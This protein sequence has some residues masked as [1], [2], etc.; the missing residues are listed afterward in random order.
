M[1]DHVYIKPVEV[2]MELFLPH[3]SGSLFAPPPY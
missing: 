2:E 1:F 3:V